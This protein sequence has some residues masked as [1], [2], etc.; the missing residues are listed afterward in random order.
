MQFPTPLPFS[1]AIAKLLE[2]G[3]LPSSFD[4]HLWSLVATE[5][6][7]KSFFSSQVESAALLDRMK[8]YIDD[9]LAVA[10][11]ENGHLKA[12]GRAEFVA[13]MRELAIREGLGKVDA[14]TG[15]IIPEIRESDMTDIRSIARLQLIFD[16]QVEAAQEYGFWLQ[17]Q[18]ESIL[19]VYPCSRFIRVR[20]VMI[21]REYH[22]AHEGEVRRKDDL[23]FWLQMNQDFGVPWGPWGFNSGMA[24][25]DVIRGEAEALGV[26]GKNEIVHPIAKKFNERLSAGVAEMDPGIAAALRQGTGGTLAGGRLVAREAKFKETILPHPSGQGIMNL[27]DEVYEELRAALSR[28]ERGGAFLGGAFP[29]PIQAKLPEFAAVEAAEVAGAAVEESVL[30]T[31]A[32]ELFRRTGKV[33]SVKWPDDAVAGA[34]MTH[35]HP[36]GG[37][38]GPDDIRAAMLHTMEGVR[39]HAGNRI[40]SV[41]PGRTPRLFL[42]DAEML[43]D[44]E[45]QRVYTEAW[46]VVNQQANAYG[47]DGIESRKEAATH[48]TWIGLARAGW[49]IYHVEKL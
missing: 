39:A 6:R 9:F 8:S 13:D 26:I 5:I 49:I 18:D 48:L 4:S 7:E 36:A 32:G 11:D 21:P 29:A 14:D 3:V 19:W 33:N 34:L 24:V 22:A 37:T 44:A 38:L 16:T 2:R 28:P 43:R 47:L 31:A 12:Q 10:R 35:T 40:Y 17:G 41:A 45:F 25:E 42:S 15:K 46:A 23:D 27:A 1:E 30:I 20:P